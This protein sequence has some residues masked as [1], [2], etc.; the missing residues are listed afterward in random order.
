MKTLEKNTELELSPN[1]SE[2]QNNINYSEIIRVEATPFTI[3]KEDEKK[4]FVTMGRFRVTE[5]VTKEEAINWIENITWD[6]IVMVLSIMIAETENV[7]DEI[8]KLTN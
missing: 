8:N 2:E 7:K 4:C 3:H 6:K 1:G 5:Q